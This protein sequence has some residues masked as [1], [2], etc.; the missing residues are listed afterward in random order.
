M[1]QL[2]CGM[3]MQ[4][5]T[6]LNPVSFS[7][8]EVGEV[9]GM[10]LDWEPGLPWSRSEYS[11]L[12]CQKLPGE[13]NRF[14]W[15]SKTEWPDESI[16][17]TD[18]PVHQYKGSLDNPNILPPVQW[19]SRLDESE[20]LVRAGRLATKVESL[21]RANAGDTHGFTEEIAKSAD[22]LT[23]AC[24]QMFLSLCRAETFCIRRIN[25]PS[26]DFTR[27]PCFV[28][29]YEYCRS[30]GEPT[31]AIC[32][33][34]W[35][36]QRANQMNTF[37]TWHFPFEVSEWNKKFEKANTFNLAEF[38]INRQHV[39]RLLTELQNSDAG[40][41]KIRSAIVRLVELYDKLIKLVKASSPD[42]QAC[43]ANV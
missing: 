13:G 1:Y 32:G 31:D 20:L 39:I 2:L 30:P 8:L 41:Q 7:A 25:D 23:E 28:T 22:E 37:A 42:K 34:E 4:D 16:L 10:Y 24:Y 17:T 38:G 3:I 26:L 33:L 14:A 43:T 29:D 5:V 6:Q 18:I 35:G 27:I 40:Y 15:L 36:L 9:F 19:Q 21:L 12:Q 11:V